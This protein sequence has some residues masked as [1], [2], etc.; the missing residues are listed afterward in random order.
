MYSPKVL[1]LLLSNSLNI[2][3][4][5]LSE[6]VS[7]YTNLRSSLSSKTNDTNINLL[8]LALYT[9]S[10]RCIVLDNTVR[11][12]EHVLIVLED[13]SNN[14]RILNFSILGVLDNLLIISS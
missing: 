2:V 6:L 12:L 4:T 5:R 3:L 10:T 11:L 13:V 1:V 14:S 8:D 9:S 7:S